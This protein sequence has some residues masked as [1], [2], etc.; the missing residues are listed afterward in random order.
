MKQAKTRRFGPKLTEF[1][2]FFDKNI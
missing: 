1:E 2:L